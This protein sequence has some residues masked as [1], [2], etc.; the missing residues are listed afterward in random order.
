M[1]NDARAVIA[2]PE[3]DIVVELIGGYG[4]AR[5]LVHGSDRGGQA[6]GHGQQGPAG[7]ARHRDLRRRPSP[8]R[9]GGV[10]GGG[11][12]RHP[13]HQGVARR[14]DGQQHRVDRRHHQRHHQFHPVRNAR[15]GAGLRRRPEG[16]A[17][18]GLRRGRPHLRHRRRGRRAQG[19]HHVGHRVRHPGAVRQ[20]LCR[21]HHQAGRAGHP[22]R[23]AAGLPHQAAG[24]HQ[25][26]LRQ[27]RAPKGIELR[28]HPAWCR[29]SA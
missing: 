16:G 21:G 20:G 26:Q 5:Q 13:D 12:R 11:G 2:N 1:V 17:A 14:P 22:L 25:A 29:P 15:Q 9:D 27:A 4:I 18:P 10:R 7:R 23:R 28:V 24:H 8:G 19:H 6:R 3:I